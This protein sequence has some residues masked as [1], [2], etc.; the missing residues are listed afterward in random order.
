MSL[1]F[2]E[3]ATGDKHELLFRGEFVEHLSLTYVAQQSVA[4]II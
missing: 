3:P 2:N 4:K 1:F